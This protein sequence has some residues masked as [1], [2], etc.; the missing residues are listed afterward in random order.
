MVVLPFWRSQWLI[1]LAVIMAAPPDARQSRNRPRSVRSC[2]AGAAC[3]HARDPPC[4]GPPSDH[5]GSNPLHVSLVALPD[6]VVSTLAGIFD[7]MNARLADGPGRPGAQPPFRVEIVGEQAGPLRL[8]SGV[9]DRRAAGDRRRRRD[10]HR[11]RAVGAAAA[12]R[13]AEGPLPA[14]GRLAAAHARARRHAVLG[15]LG[16]LP[17]GRDRA[18]RRQGRHRAFRLRPRLRGALSGRADPSRAR[19]G[20]LR[21]ARGAGQLGRVDDL[22]R[23][24]AVPHRAP[25]RR[26]RGAGGGAPVRAAMA[27]GRTCALHRLRGQERPRRRRDPE[28]AALAGQR[29]SRWPIRWRR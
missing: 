9:P 14:A 29:T 15:L 5:T 1:E 4:H 26:H 16:H 24:G 11:D 2:H 13:L 3:G 28:R 18:V 25:R 10:R 8:A 20:D 7:V 12:G 27:S 19:A 23:H 6:A 17:A 22:A 21:P